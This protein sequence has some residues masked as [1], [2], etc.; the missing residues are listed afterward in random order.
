MKT[1]SMLFTGVLAA[2][3]MFGGT[4]TASTTAELVEQVAAQNPGATPE[5]ILRGAQEASATSGETVEAVLQSALNESRESTADSLSV[6]LAAHDT[7]VTTNSS[8]GGGGGTAVTLG[9][10][11]RTGDVFYSPASTLFIQHGHSGIY[12][13]PDYIVEAPGTGKVVRY[14]SSQNVKVAPGAKKQTVD[15]SL[16]VRTKARDF[17][18][19]KRGKPYN[20]NFAFNKKVTADKYN[21]SQLVWASYK[22]AGSID[23]DSN[24]GTGV[25][26]ANIRDS[27][28]TTTYQTL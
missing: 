2:S 14:I 27:S 18:Y 11:N 21:C 15:A 23:L 4:A 3:M 13:S 1:K 19:S 26:P 24:G 5:D 7:A 10:G 22:S 25:Y 9:A 12:F 6:S 28:Y 17:A 20:T 8:S 16:T